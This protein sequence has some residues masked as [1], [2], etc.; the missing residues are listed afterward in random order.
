MFLSFNSNFSTAVIS[1]QQ[2]CIRSRSQRSCTKNQVELAP[3]ALD[4]VFSYHA[5]MAS[6]TGTAPSPSTSAASDGFKASWFQVESL[7]ALHH[8]ADAHAGKG[9][10]S[11]PD[12]NGFDAAEWE[13]LAYADLKPTV[14]PFRVSQAGVGADGKPLWFIQPCSAPAV[15][16]SAFAALSRLHVVSQH[17][18]EGSALIRSLTTPAST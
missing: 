2:D 18:R 15:C 6:A 11:T 12:G 17:T 7:P 9:Q 16:T 4:A 8:L 1:A 13:S 5:S 3:D 14:D 10:S